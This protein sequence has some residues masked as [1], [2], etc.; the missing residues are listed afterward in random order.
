MRFFVFQL[1]QSSGAHPDAEV[2]K[3]ELDL[4]VEAEQLGFDAVWIAEH[5]FN[6]Y[7]SITPEP[8][9]VAAHL[10]ARTS[11]IRVGSAANIAGM[12]HP[13]RMAEMG[14][15]LD[16]ISGGRADIGLA[17]GF[18][19]REFAGY[20]VSVTELNERF[21]EG[22]E[23]AIQAWTQPDFSYTGKY[24]SVPKVSLRP[25]PVTKP[26]PRAWIATTGS[27]ETLRL[28]ARYRLPFYFG[29]RDQAQLEKVRG[30]F[31][32]QARAENLP[33]G[34]AQRV[35]SQTAVIQHVHLSHSR[36]Q[37]Y[38]EAWAGMQGTK[39]SL[40]ALGIQPAPGEPTGLGPAWSAP[41]FEQ[42]KALEHYLNDAIAGEPSRGL[43]RI[44]QLKAM[45]VQNLLLSFSF[46][47]LPYEA[48]RRSMELFSREVLP[49]VR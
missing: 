5:H 16:V 3:R 25:R 28:A 45:G 36:D 41:P 39:A 30:T 27:A 49:R 35:W 33:D 34:E 19:P 42:S 1:M 14:A 48:A 20:G 13:V 11:R 44:H 38:A 8:L 12:P 26:H 22:V 6:S 47:G 18:G 32:E 43:E 4:M 7:W 23:I 17:K 29:A 24:Y 15:M 21:R 46:G 31:F 2:Y 9:L 10:A 40:G 37:A